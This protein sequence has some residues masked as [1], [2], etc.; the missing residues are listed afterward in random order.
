MNGLIHPTDKMTSRERLLAAYHGR[1]VDRLPYWAKIAVND[2]WRRGQ[3][4]PVRSMAA[5]ALLDHI[6]A[7]GIFS[8][9]HAVRVERPHVSTTTTRSETEI[10]TV[11]HTPDG[12]LN[13]RWAIDPSTGS[14]HPTVFPIRSLDDLRRYRWVHTDLKI[15]VDAGA[16]EK[17]RD[18]AAVGQRGVTICWWGTSP[19]MNLVEHV[20]GPEE[21][22]IFLHEN[23]REMEELMDL[24]HQGNIRLATAVA[25]SSP[26]DIV[27]SGENTSTTLIS[28]TQFQ[29]YCHRHLCDYAAAIAAQG[30]LPELHMCG[31]LLKIL[32]VI[33][34]VPAVSI[35]AFTSPALGNTRLCDGRAL[36]PS[37][38]LVGGTNVNVWLMP[39]A[40]IQ[41]YIL[42]ELAACPNHRRIVL[43]TAGV[44][45]P[46]C[47]LETFRQIGQW[48][49]TVPLRL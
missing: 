14:I 32:P 47:P 6:F 2:T 42:D 40:K 24:M 12:D 36:A 30:K 4:E 3:P 5:E 37:K 22:H 19:L 45:P 35:E 38:T 27:V 28:P 17:V 20:V 29:K 33:D 41:Q 18:R 49:P 43:T 8:C 23:A 44:A 48:L 13:E 16:L 25:A 9:G 10:V 34:T 46:G 7:D 21:T 26:A 31:H 15:R 39:L 11:I 1:E